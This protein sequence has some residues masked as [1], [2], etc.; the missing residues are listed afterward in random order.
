[1]DHGDLKSGERKV[2]IDKAER[3]AELREEQYQII[4]AFLRD[5]QKSK[6]EVFAGA[7]LEIP[8]YENQLM[9]DIKSFI[10]Q[11]FSKDLQALFHYARDEVFIRIRIDYK[12]QRTRKLKVYGIADALKNEIAQTEPFIPKIAEE[13]KPI[14]EKNKHL[15]KEFLRRKLREEFLKITMRPEFSVMRGRHKTLAM[16]CTSQKAKDVF[17]K[18]E[19]EI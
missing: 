4:D 14:K 1:M 13:L 17:E 18:V 2:I 9:A 16:W 7:L 19:R 10:K 15:G 5:Y 6:T 11:N 8:E 12:T 3:L